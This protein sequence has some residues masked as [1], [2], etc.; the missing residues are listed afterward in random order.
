[1]NIVQVKN[2]VELLQK[3]N[4]KPYALLPEVAKEFKV[5]KTELM[6]FIDEEPDRIY[7]ENVWSYKE[8]KV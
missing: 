6:K 4:N 5:S 2:V 8:K 1:M 3:A 7:C